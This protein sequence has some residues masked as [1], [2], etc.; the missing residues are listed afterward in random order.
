MKTELIVDSSLIIIKNPPMKDGAID[1]DE[2]ALTQ[3]IKFKTPVKVLLSSKVKEEKMFGMIRIPPGGEI[4]VDGMPIL[5][6]DLDEQGAYAF[7]PKCKGWWFRK[8]SG[9][10]KRCPECNERLDKY[11][12]KEI[13]L[14]EVMKQEKK[15]L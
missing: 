6:G 13:E 7:C 1:L 5:N 3:K 14:K 4:E 12:A 2:L 15:F 8:T 10:P 11:A 9:R